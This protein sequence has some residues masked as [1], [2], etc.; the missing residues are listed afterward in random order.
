MTPCVAAMEFLRD[1]D[2]RA[3]AVVEASSR[4]GRPVAAR[5]SASSTSRLDAPLAR[6]VSG[7]ARDRGRREGGR[8]RTSAEGRAAGRDGMDDATRERRDE[9][10]TAFVGVDR[11]RGSRVVGSAATTHR[12]RTPPSP[13]TAFRL[14]SRDQSEGRSSSPTATRSRRGG[15]SRGGE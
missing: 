1:D 5:L 6:S 10:G 8:E 14:A 2:R 11:Y 3:D 13:S 9:N 15:G 4:I 7:G 12:L